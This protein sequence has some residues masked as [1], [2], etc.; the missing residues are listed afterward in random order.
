MSEYSSKSLD[1][2]TAEVLDSIA[3]K[4]RPVN[5][6]HSKKSILDLLK[7]QGRADTDAKW[8]GI[9]AHFKNRRNKEGV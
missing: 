6:D 9:E 1:A 5:S 8:K 3:A 7:D 4:Y 2:M